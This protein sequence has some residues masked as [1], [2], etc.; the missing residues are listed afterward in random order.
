MI[1]LCYRR[2]DSKLVAFHCRRAV[3][4]LPLGV[5]Q[6]K[7][8]LSRVTFHPPLSEVKREAISAL[9]MGAENKVIMQFDLCRWPSS[10]AYLNCTDQR[11]RFINLH[12]LG[13]R[14]VL[15]AHTSPPFSYELAKLSDA[16]VLAEVLAV[17]H[18]MF[19]HTMGA[20]AGYVQPKTYHVT[21]WHQYPFSM[22]SYSFLKIGSDTESVN[23]LARAEWGGRLRFAGEATSVAEQ[24]CVTGA[25]TT[26]VKAAQAVVADLLGPLKQ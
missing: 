18:K 9:G 19:P 6:G 26:G 2:S 3:V 22:G 4:T 5:L 14:G 1:V 12:R 11:F 20:E 25:F 8:R 16:A 15:V 23:A 21:R 13:K 17:L 7:H 10:V 24:Q